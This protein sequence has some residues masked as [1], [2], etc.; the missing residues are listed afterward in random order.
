MT[1]ETSSA[2][3]YGIF[4]AIND[5]CRA[6][7]ESARALTQAFV[8]VEKNAPGFSND[9]CEQVHKRAD[10]GPKACEYNYD[11]TLLALSSQPRQ[12]FQLSSNRFSFVFSFFNT[13]GKTKTRRFSELSRMIQGR[14]DALKKILS[15][16]PSVIYDRPT[17]LQTIKGLGS[18]LYLEH[19]Y[20]LNIDFGFF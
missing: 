6:D 15:R 13:L 1:N 7:P 20:L 8:K 2:L 9:F 4:P 17:F 3:L 19:V 16:I 18:K 11:A 12:E 10:K 5:I 14:A